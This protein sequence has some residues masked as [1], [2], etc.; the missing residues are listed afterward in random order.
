MTVFKTFQVIEKGM[1]R[2]NVNYCSYIFHVGSI[3]FLFLL[4]TMDFL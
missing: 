1:M 3:S 2:E 4:N